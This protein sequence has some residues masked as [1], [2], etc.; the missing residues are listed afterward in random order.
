MPTQFLCS[1]R[2][3]RSQFKQLIDASERIDIFVASFDDEKLAQIL[4]RAEP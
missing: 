3:I 4:S 1:P 2:D